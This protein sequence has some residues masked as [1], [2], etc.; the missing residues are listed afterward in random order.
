VTTWVALFRGINV[1]GHNKLPMRT[2]V[3]AFAAIGAEDTRTYIQSGNVVFRHEE[4]D[5]EALVAAIRAAV[6]KVV[7]FEPGILLMTAAQFEQVL[8][9]NPF[10]ED[11][12]NALHVYFL[13]AAPFEPDL[14]ALATAASSTEQFALKGVAFYLHAPDGIARSKIA[15]SVER[16]LGV[17]ATARNWRTV[18]GVRELCGEL[19]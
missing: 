9:K 6:G 7:D 5:R 4:A 19:D 13:A 11:P 1:G 12:P 18:S 16:R 3:E 17:S 14:E 10:P 15:A 2:L 8:Q